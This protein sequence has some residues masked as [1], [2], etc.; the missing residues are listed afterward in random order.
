MSIVSLSSFF[1]SLFV[2][3]T[4]DSINSHTNAHNKIFGRY[5]AESVSVEHE[6]IPDY[7]NFRILLWK[8][9]SKCPSTIEEKSEDVVKIFFEFIR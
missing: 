8:V 2:L 4:N 6:E 7:F 1:F 9:M 5:F 3:E